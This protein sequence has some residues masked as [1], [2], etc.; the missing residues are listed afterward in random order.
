[1][2]ETKKKIRYKAFGLSILSELPLPEL[3]QTIG[4]EVLMLSLK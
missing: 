4:E 2:I 3:H 1:M